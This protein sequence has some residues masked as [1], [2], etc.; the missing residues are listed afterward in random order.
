MPK[1]APAKSKARNPKASRLL[2][3][4]QLSL[5]DAGRKP[6]KGDRVVVSSTEF[7]VLDPRYIGHAGTV[8]LVRDIP[9]TPRSEEYQQLTV[10]LD[11]KYLGRK[12]LC[13]RD[14]CFSI[15]SGE[16]AKPELPQSRPRKKRKT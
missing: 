4:S 6:V 10:T 5:L 14:A 1:S 15:I 3:G 7:S 16:P 8:A 9:A 11:R 12:T 2:E 13:L